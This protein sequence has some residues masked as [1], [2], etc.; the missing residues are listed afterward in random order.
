LE[1]ETA[2]GI[3]SRYTRMAK[4]EGTTDL[5]VGARL[6]STEKDRMAGNVSTI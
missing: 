2:V 5:N 6:P 4:V 3:V 1:I